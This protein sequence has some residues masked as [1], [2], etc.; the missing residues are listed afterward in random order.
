MISRK[1]VCGVF[2]VPRKHLAIALRV[3][4]KC[5]F[6]LSQLKKRKSDTNHQTRKEGLERVNPVA[7]RLAS[8]HVNINIPMIVLDVFQD[9]SIGLGT[10]V[11]DFDFLHRR[12]I[13]LAT[14]PS[15]LGR[16]IRCS[17]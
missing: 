16:L 10:L 9:G 8:V 14:S 17:T 13:P 11:S 7:R 15:I 1:H 12:H 6:K 3:Q 2:Y 4:T 5:K